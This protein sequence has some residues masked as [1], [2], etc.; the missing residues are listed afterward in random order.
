MVDKFE[1]VK[2]PVQSSKPTL[3]PQDVKALSARFGSGTHTYNNSVVGTTDD[4]MRQLAEHF[5]P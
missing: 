3:S 1:S 2:P 4:R 5:T